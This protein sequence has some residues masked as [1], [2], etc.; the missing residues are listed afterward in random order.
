MNFEGDVPRSFDWPP[1]SPDLNSCDFFL[2]GYLKSK[3]YIHRPRSIEQLQNAI[4]QKSV[5]IPHEMIRRVLDNFRKSL[6][7][8]V[9]NKG[10]LCNF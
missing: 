2:R 4:R 3:V 1:Q 10:D 5:T 7:Q 6:R 9:D 8:C